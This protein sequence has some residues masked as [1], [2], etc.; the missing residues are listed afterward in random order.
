[1]TA[2]DLINLLY[3]CDPDAEVVVDVVTESIIYN[4]DNVEEKDGKV[5]LF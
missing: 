4:I 3:E 2:D 1:M 5:V